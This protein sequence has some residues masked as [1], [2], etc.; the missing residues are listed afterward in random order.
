MEDEER[1][2]SQ[3]EMLGRIA[4]IGES[5]AR[6]ILSIH[7]RLDRIFVTKE[8]FNPVKNIAYGLVAMILVAFIGALT[9]MV[10]HTK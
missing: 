9:V 8:E 2:H 6:D 7:D 10:M 4:A 1:R 5:N 3:D